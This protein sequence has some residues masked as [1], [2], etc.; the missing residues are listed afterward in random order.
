MPATLPELRAALGFCLTTPGEEGA[1]MRLVARLDL[2]W[3]GCGMSR[4]G[5]RH[6]VGHHP[7]LFVNPRHLGPR[8]I[9]VFLP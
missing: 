2:F 9:S 3:L 8:R 4:E 1:A 7:P 6:P 5:R